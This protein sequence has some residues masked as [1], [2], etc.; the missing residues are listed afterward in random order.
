MIQ[1]IFASDWLL[2]AFVVFA[3]G[4]AGRAMIPKARPTKSV[5]DIAF[6]I[7]GVLLFAAGTAISVLMVAVWILGCALDGCGQGP[8]YW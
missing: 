4:V 2:S 7:I 1:K 5:V 8:G 3:L 6:T